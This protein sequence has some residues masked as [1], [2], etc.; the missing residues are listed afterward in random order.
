M[1]VLVQVNTANTPDGATVQIDIPAPVNLSKSETVAGNMVEIEFTTAE[2][3]GV[4]SIQPTALLIVDGNTVDTRQF[5]KYIN[6]FNGFELGDWVRYAGSGGDVTYSGTDAVFTGTLADGWE[7]AVNPSQFQAL[8]RIKNAQPWRLYF[9]YQHSGGSNY[10]VYY[11]DPAGGVTTT[12]STS[13][14][15]LNVDPSGSD[16]VNIAVDVAADVYAARGW[17][18]TGIDLVAF[19]GSATIADVS[20]GEGQTATPPHVNVV[21]GGSTLPDLGPLK[22]LPGAEGYGSDTVAGRGAPIILVTNNNDSGAG[23]LRAALETPGPKRIFLNAA[24]RLQPTSPMFLTDPNCTIYGQ[25]APGD[26]M[27]FVNPTNVDRTW[28]SIEASDVAVC[29]LNIGAGA[30]PT[31]TPGGNGN[32]RGMNINDA[33]GSN[34]RR[35]IVKNCSFK[36]ATD[37]LLSYWYNAQDLC[38]QDNLLAEPLQNSTHSSGLHGFAFLGGTTGSTTISFHRNVMSQIAGRGPLIAISDLADVRNNLIFNSIRSMQFDSIRSLPGQ[39]M[40]GNMVNN[41]FIDGANRGDW[42]EIVMTDH[43]AGGLSAYVQGNRRITLANTETDPRYID[44]LQS[45]GKYVFFDPNNSSFCT[46]TEHAMA[47]VSTIAANQLE[48]ELLD[49]IGALPGRRE[50]ND[51]RI[52]SD[53]YERKSGI[54]D[55][56]PNGL[57][58]LADGDSR[59]DTSRDDFTTE[60]FRFQYSIPDN[61]NCLITGDGNGQGWTLEDQFLEWLPLQAA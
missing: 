17:T 10:F 3:N 22:G 49:S 41:L 9:R 7:H 47:P 48:G 45:V 33:R 37:Q 4:D 23:S 38:I 29:H 55:N 14:K 25:T 50:G 1:S 18:V 31:N 52:I 46:S 53:I 35:V 32:G 61:T 54:V 24:G 2:L 12:T 8:V 21:A 58:F 42:N 57:P 27:M 34:V 44:E 13:G 51:A 60:A 28:L 20:F 43:G 39:P 19:R 56:P 30:G 36:W 15:R 26:G 11:N 5:P 59:I 6:A 40:R 16:F